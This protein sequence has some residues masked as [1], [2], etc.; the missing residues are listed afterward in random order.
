MLVEFVNCGD[1]ECLTCLRNHSCPKTACMEDPCV[2]CEGIPPY[3][4]W[5]ADNKLYE[6]NCDEKKSSTINIR[7]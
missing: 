3:A 6:Y 2:D 7:D 1:C 5:E 4:P